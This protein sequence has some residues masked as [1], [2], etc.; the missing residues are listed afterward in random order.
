M[1]GKHWLWSNIYSRNKDEEILRDTA[2]V[3]GPAIFFVVDRE[4]NVVVD[5]RVEVR[6]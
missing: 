6:P 5:G 2:F 4:K 1:L 3:L